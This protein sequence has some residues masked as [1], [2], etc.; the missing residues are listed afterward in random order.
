MVDSFSQYLKLS[1]ESRKRIKAELLDVHENCGK[2]DF[3]IPDLYDIVPKEEI[4]GFEAI[5][6]KIITEIISEASGIVCWVYV[7]KYIDNKTLNEML[8]EWDGLINLLL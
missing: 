5:M 3:Q 2:A 6:Q 7:E 1:E 8:E 4:A